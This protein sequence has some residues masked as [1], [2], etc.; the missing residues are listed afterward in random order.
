MCLR[1]AAALAALGGAES[2][3]RAGGPPSR[4][5][6]QSLLPAV[7]PWDVGPS[8]VGPPAGRESPSHDGSQ[9]T[10]GLATGQA[11]VVLFGL[12][13]RAA[14]C[15]RPAQRLNV[16]APLEA[17][18]LN[19]TV[20]E[21]TML[22]RRGAMVDGVVYKRAEACH[23]DLCDFANQSGI[24]AAANAFVKQRC[25]PAPQRACAIRGQKFAYSRSPRRLQNMIRQL[26]S[27]RLVAERLRRAEGYDV[28]IALSEDIAPLQPL[29]RA[30]VDAALR[31][32]VVVASHSL[33]ATRE[34][35]TGSVTPRPRRGD[36]VHTSRG[37]AAATTWIVRGRV[38]APPRLRP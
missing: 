34:Q 12:H 1:A 2:R 4:R 16:L 28:A 6:G 7:G 14:G 24:D 29:T 35:S 11:L 18:G 9:R 26:E 8:G 33:D 30:D 21:L 3:L 10:R 5:G 25:K 19:V 27:E 36:S 13:H 15:A 22:P 38:A 32:N 31:G 37:D 17:A 20:W 23:Y